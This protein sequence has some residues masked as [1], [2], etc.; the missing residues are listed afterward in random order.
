MNSTLQRL[1]EIKKTSYRLDLGDAINDIFANYKNI[2]LLGGAVILLVSIVA[3]VIFGGTATLFFGINELTQTLTD[4]SAGTV[5][6]TALIVGF[7][8]SS[9]GAGLF[10]PV[11]AG[12]IQMAHNS[13]INEDYDFGT[14][15]M[16][17]KS[18]SF[19][20]LFLSGALLTLIGSVPGFFIELYYLNNP[21]IAFHLV[22]NGI[23][24]IFSVLLQIF[25]LM[26]VPLIIFGKLNAIDAIKGS[27]IIVSKHF[28]IILLLVIVCG[29][30]V[31]LGI[32]ALCIGI[33]F[34]IPIMYS[35]QYIIYK[36]ALP[37]DEVDELDEIGENRF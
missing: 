5:T 17:Y 3:L 1:Q 34:T 32:L 8:G 14:A 21:N 37:I 16:H 23:S 33:L 29:I 22:G 20:E 10:A 27:L 31:G 9:I 30:F 24:N 19:K 15:F 6:N 12:I 25:T 4:Y 35:M 11:A 2:A 26:T 18:S 13:S 7:I 36:S 28:W